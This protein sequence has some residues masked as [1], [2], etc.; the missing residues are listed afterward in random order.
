[1]NSRKKLLR[2][3]EDNN[4]INVNRDIYENYEKG[5]IKKRV[6]KW[7]NITSVDDFIR[8]YLKYIYESLETE[9]RNDLQFQIQKVSNF[10]NVTSPEI[11]YKEKLEDLRKLLLVLLDNINVSL[12]DKSDKTVFF[13]LQCCHL[14][15]SLSDTINCFFIMFPKGNLR[16]HKQNCLSKILCRISKNLQVFDNIK[17]LQRTL[18]ENL[19]S[20]LIDPNGYIDTLQPLESFEFLLYN[21]D[22]NKGFQG[23]AESKYLRQLLILLT[24]NYLVT[25]NSTSLLLNITGYEYI[26]QFINFII[27]EL[28]RNK[29]TEITY[30]YLN[31]IRDFYLKTEFYCKRKIFL[32]D[33]SK[34]TLSSGNRGKLGKVQF[35][36]KRK[37]KNR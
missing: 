6:N 8:H 12:K 9:E 36:E 30:H 13:R 23:S 2:Y 24:Q 32:K 4:D 29:D 7:E 34:N 22:R 27:F 5:Y 16:I 20:C 25:F 15:W 1:M 31:S 17:G 37:E 3:L 11:I 33:G 21:F 10:L 18:F 35:K 26:K 28:K 19:E 14:L